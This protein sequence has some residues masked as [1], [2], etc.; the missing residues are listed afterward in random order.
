MR[1]I[2]PIAVLGSLVDGC[3]LNRALPLDVQFDG[4]VEVWRRLR[5][6]VSRR[7]TLRLWTRAS[8]PPAVELDGE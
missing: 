3:T 7:S 2:L 5:C 6:V 1:W 8:T 4:G